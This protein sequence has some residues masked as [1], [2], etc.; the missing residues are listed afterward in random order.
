M[1]SF[2]LN[3]L[4]RA[5]ISRIFDERV[6]DLI[7]KK[8]IKFPVYLSAGQE[9]VACTIAEICNMKKN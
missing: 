2:R 7:E 4:N 5:S 8:I 6:Y 9:Y 3:V 1:K